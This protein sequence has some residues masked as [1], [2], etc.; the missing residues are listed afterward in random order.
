MENLKGKNILYIV[1]SYNNF[2]KDQIDTTAKYFNKVYVLSRYEPLAEIARIIPLSSIKPL[3]LEHILQ[4][5]DKPD[6]VEVY[7]VPLYYL[8]IPHDTPKSLN[9]Q[10]PKKAL[11]IIRDKNIRFDIIHSHFNFPS[12]AVGKRCKEVFKVP[13]VLTSH[14]FDIYRLPYI[15]DQY[16]QIVSGII[17]SADVKITV[18]KSNLKHFEYMGIDSNEVMVRDNGFN[19]KMFYPADNITARKKLG[20]PLDKSV[21]LTIGYLREVKGQK[22]LIDAIKD[23]IKIHPDIICY[24]IGDGVLKH[25][26]EKQI[27]ALSLEGKVILTGGKSH[28]EIPDWM[29]ACDLFCLPSISESFGVVQIEALACGKPVVATQNGGSD[30]LIV[31]EDIGFLTKNKDY[32][33]LAENIIK[34]LEKKWDKKKILDYSDK[35]KWENICKNIASIYNKLLNN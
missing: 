22:Y 34:A 2:Q 7:P 14:G 20:I 16:K 23:V 3:T 21:I 19:S 9:T 15:D 25:K 10:M 18:S 29:N 4:L 35:F 17:K 8:P 32:K 24:I 6:N 27:K 12:G 5:D 33:S 1:N 30:Y 13:F 28:K 31:N 11:K 26:L